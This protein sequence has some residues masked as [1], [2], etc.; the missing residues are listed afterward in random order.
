VDDP[1]VQFDPGT[2]EAATDDTRPT[3]TAQRKALQP[4]PHKLDT[5]SLRESKDAPRMHFFRGNRYKQ[6]AIRFDEKPDQQS[7]RPDSH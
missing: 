2:L 4:D 3:Q 5:I 1:A 7:T 6:I